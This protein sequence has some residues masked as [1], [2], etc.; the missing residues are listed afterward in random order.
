MATLGSILRLARQRKRLKQ[1]HVAAEL[2]ISVPAVGQ[3]ERDEVKPIQANLLDVC[4]YLQID[5]GAAM[6]GILK[7]TSGAG[8]AGAGD[9]VDGGHIDSEAI[10]A[11]LENDD[12]SV[13]QADPPFEG[14]VAQITGRMGGGSTGEVITLHAGEM[15]TIEPVAAWWSIPPEALSGFG[16]RDI[17]PR[18][19][20]GWFMDGA[21]ME[22]TIQR[23]DVVFIDTRRRSPDPEGIFAVDYGE[24]R[25]LK[26]ISV[27]RSPEGVKF[28]LRSDNADRFKPVI[29]AAD[30]V[31]IFG[32]YLFRFTVF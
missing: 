9:E 19:I 5:P 11:A 26:R 18:H 23:T 15:R 21:S 27:I 10:A 2:G 29:R 12:E 1:R 6:I 20:V 30:E 7:D 22:P 24:G 14:A 25:T 32:R 13:N 16:F 3:W 17:M 8:R 28:E 4:R 31:T